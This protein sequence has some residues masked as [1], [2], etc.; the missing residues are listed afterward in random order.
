MRP[1][2]RGDLLGHVHRPG[3]LPRAG[4]EEARVQHT[5]DVFM[6]ERSNPLRIREMFQYQRNSEVRSGEIR[7]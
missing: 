1:G 4:F 5:L 6:P 7:E 3:R 2:R